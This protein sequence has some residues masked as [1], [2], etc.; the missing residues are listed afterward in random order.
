MGILEECLIR[1]VPPYSTPNPN[2]VMD[3]GL[4]ICRF[5]DGMN[6][7]VDEYEQTKS[8]FGFV[9]RRPRAERSREIIEHLAE[10]VAN[11][12]SALDIINAYEGALVFYEDH[13]NRTCRGGPKNTEAET[14]E[15]FE[16]IRTI[17]IVPFP[18]CCTADTELP[19]DSGPMNRALHVMDLVEKAK[20]FGALNHIIS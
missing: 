11:A 15:K 8:V 19:N 14:I 3:V 17:A 12:S 5:E 4:V 1:C 7:I 9:S 13:G 16:R 18:S 20:F 10:D 2:R 6:R